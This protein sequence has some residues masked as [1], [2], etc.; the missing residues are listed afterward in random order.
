VK[1]SNSHE[2]ARCLQQFANFLLSRD[3]FELP[4]TTPTTFHHMTYYDPEDKGRF[5][6]AVKAL[7]T[8]EKKFTEDHVEFIVNAPGTDA[9]TIRAPRHVICR[10][11]KPAKY[12]CDPLFSPEEV[13]QLGGGQ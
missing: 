9:F 2:Y 3:A 4:W 6:A 7:G 10:L 1:N 13:S 12:E 5:I 11:L 8:G